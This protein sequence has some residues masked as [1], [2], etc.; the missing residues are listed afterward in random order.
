MSEYLFGTHTGHLTAAADRIAKRHGANHV[1]YTEPGGQRR[2]WFACQNR[3]DPFDGA[4]ARAV[5]A[6][7]EQAGGLNALR[8]ARDK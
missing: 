8:Y 5:A 3:G 1:N 2:G 6:E 7:I 4:T